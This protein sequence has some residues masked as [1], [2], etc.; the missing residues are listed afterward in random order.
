MCFPISL[1]FSEGFQL[2]L[3]SEFSSYTNSTNISLM[4]NT[5]AFPVKLGARQCLALWV[6]SCWIQGDGERADSVKLG[7]Q[8]AL[9]SFISHP[10]NTSSY[11]ARETLPGR[12]S[13]FAC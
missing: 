1:R 3:P 6:E 8:K 9:A 5:H 4:M 12:L 10:V 13:S 11:V 7:L 2:L